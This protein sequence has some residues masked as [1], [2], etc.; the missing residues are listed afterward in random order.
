[1][2]KGKLVSNNTK[3]LNK[4]KT[5]A[6]QGM[7]NT[8]VPLDAFG[9]LAAI[10]LWY[11]EEREEQWKMSIDIWQKLMEIM[12]HER[13]DFSGEEIDAFNIQCDVFFELWVDW[14][15]LEG[16]PY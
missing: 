12:A 1:L 13:E 8:Y 14:T 4:E 7:P 3:K 2:G 5:I 9:Q 16:M 10:F 11:D 15:G 6:D